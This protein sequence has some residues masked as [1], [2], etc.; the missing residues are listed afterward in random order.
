MTWPNRTVES[1]LIETIFRQIGMHWC[2]VRSFLRDFKA[3]WLL[4]SDIPEVVI[5]SVPLRCG[6]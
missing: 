2:L 1:N 5:S 4:D 3:Q 6:Y